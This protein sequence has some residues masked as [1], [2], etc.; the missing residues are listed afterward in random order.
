MNSMTENAR[1]VGIVQRIAEYAQSVTVMAGLTSMTK[2]RSTSRQA[3]SSRRAKY[4]V[5]RASSGGVRSAEPTFKK[6]A[7]S[8]SAAILIVAGLVLV[9]NAYILIIGL[10]IGYVRSA[11]RRPKCFERSDD[12]FL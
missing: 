11:T 7:S 6:I 5:D 3:K 1:N 12:D 8:V 4:V 9:Y 2:T 10:R